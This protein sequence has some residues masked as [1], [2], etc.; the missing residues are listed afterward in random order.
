MM[1][2]FIIRNP[3]ST[4]GKTWAHESTC[5]VVNLMKS[6]YGSSV[7]QRKYKVP[8]KCTVSPKYIPD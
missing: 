2:N 1:L 3:L 8:I 6:K 4:F 5:L 7:F